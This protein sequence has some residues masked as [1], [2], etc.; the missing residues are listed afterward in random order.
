MS[1]EQEAQKKFE[2]VGYTP[3]HVA[4]YFIYR[5]EEEK[6]TDLTVMKLLKLVY[7]GYAWSLAALNKKL[8][9]EPIEAWRHGPVVPSLYHEFKYRGQA[10]ID[11]YS[12][13]VEVDENHRM[14]LTVPHIKDTEYLTVLHAVW[15]TYKQDDAFKLSDTLHKDNSA[16]NKVYKAGANNPLHDADIWISAAKKIDELGSQNG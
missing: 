12:D 7:I 8:F 11:R 9:D 13:I 2:S 15:H 10:N 16:W 3:S 4:N 6:I 1:Q 5:A 14:T